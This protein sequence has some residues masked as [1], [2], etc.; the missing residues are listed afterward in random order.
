MEMKFCQSC[1]M[2]L[3]ED[4]LGTNADGTKNEEYCVYC[5]KDGDFV[6]GDCTVEEMI[7]FCV[8]PTLQSNPEMKEEE[9]RAMLQQ[10]LPTLKRWQ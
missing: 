1:G 2:P 4:V 6:G 7:E 9:V 5:Y 8:E 3:S 10:F